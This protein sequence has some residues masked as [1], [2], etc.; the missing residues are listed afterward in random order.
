[1][2]FGI[3]IYG[4]YYSIVKEGIYSEILSL[5][6][7]VHINLGILWDEGSKILRFPEVVFRLKKMPRSCFCETAGVDGTVSLSS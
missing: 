2:Y 7:Y 5:R 4:E 1:M 6:T 3:I